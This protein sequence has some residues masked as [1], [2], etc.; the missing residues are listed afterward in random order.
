MEI[1]NFRFEDLPGLVA[2]MNR[3]AEAVGRQATFTVEQI[4]RS[5]RAPHNH[6]E[7]DAFLAIENGEIVGYTISDLLDKPQ[8]AFG[9]Y[10]VLPEHHAASQA[11]MTAT[12]AHFRA[13]AFE[14]SPPDVEIALDWIIP[15]ANKE[16]IEWCEAQGFPLVRQ[17]FTMRMT[18]AEPVIALTLPAGFVR[19]PFEVSHLDAVVTAK[20]EAF[21]DHWGDQHDTFDEWQ[22][23]IQ[24]DNFDASL[25]WIV[26]ADD[27]IAG[28]LLSYPANTERS[29]ISI[30]GV[31]RAWRKRGLAQTMLSQCFAEYQRR[32]FTHVY[33]DVDSD[34]PTR[35]VAL[36]ERMGMHVHNSTRYYRHVLRGLQGV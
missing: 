4:E 34:S 36:Y 30:L 13:V 35:A 22:H 1:R 21:E 25:W 2:F 7:D 8:Y 9:V 27:D 24:Q 16:A 17:F 18:L 19:R 26:Y 14:A 10:Q 20:V 12:T 33:L 29:Y 3:Y 28:I 15:Q 23:A 11:L 31:R 5:W 6:P 32:G